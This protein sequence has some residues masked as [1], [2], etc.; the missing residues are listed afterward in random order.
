MEMENIIKL[1]QT[2]SDSALTS[3]RYVEG[4]SSLTLEINRN[5]VYSEAP[6]IKT[7]HVYVDTNMVKENAKTNNLTIT[8]PMVG[9]FYCAKS[10]DSE[11]FISVGDTV[12]KGQVI[13]IVEAMKLMNEIES[14]YDGV[15][16]AI[17]VKNKD[18][19]EYGQTLVSIR[20]L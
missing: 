11:P 2:V 17:L 9:T 12:K 8:S 15:V 20:P 13:G 1:I 4:D 19:V 14:E 16:E 10:E 5:V 6:E 7:S 3:F 18:M